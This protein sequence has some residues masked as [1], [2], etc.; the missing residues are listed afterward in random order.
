[1]TLLIHDKLR[2]EMDDEQISLLKTL[3]DDL[4]LED[5]QLE[6]LLEDERAVQVMEHLKDIHNTAVNEG[7]SSKTARPWLQYL[8]MLKILFGFLRLL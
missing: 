2:N 4:L 8:D 5:S 6:S 7:K 3:L 1:M